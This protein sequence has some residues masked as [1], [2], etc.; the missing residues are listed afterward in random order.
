[1]VIE[2]AFIRRFR[3]SPRMVVTVATIGITQLL[4]VLGILIP[5]W[6]GQN[7][8]SERIAPPVWKLEAHASAT[9]DPQRQPPH[10]PGR[11]AAD[12]GGRRLVPGQQPLGVAIRASAE[13]SD[14]AAML[15]IP[16]GRLNTL[17]WAIAAAMSFVAL[18]LRS[19]IIGVP[20]R[21]RGRVAGAARSAR[22]AR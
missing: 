13:R 15:G 2:F 7:L 17:V 6:W 8:A 5:R 19:G 12:D 20:A 18:F 1:M 16:V 14:R 10:R 9:G 3:N 4:V 11:R 22:R 21:L